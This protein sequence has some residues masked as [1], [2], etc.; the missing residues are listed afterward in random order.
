[1]TAPL[2]NNSSTLAKLLQA[3]Q[4]YVT[5]TPALL[6]E[7]LKRELTIKS[8]AEYNL[9]PELM[10]LLL[11][12]EAQ[13]A[14]TETSPSLKIVSAERGESSG[15]KSPKWTLETDTGE[16]LWVFQHKDPARNNFPLFDEAGWGAWLKGLPLNQATTPPHQMALKATKDTSGYYRVTE[17]LTFNPLILPTPPTIDPKHRVALEDAIQR[18]HVWTS[19]EMA[20]TKKYYVLDTETTGLETWDEVV[21]LSIADA[22]TGKLLLET[23]VKPYAAPIGFTAQDIHGITPEMVVNAP[24]IHEVKVNGVPLLDFLAAADGVI[25]WNADFDSRLVRQTFFV[26]GYA[27]LPAI[28]WECAMLLYG[29]YNGEW[30][31]KKG[32]YKWW[33]LVDA[34]RVEKI[35]TDYLPHTSHGDV[36]NTIALLNKIAS[37]YLPF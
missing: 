23:L 32:G 8:V 18:A 37:L 1:M 31:A 19:T 36:M 21:S 13:F 4:P 9:P 14:E 7:V 27:T 26:G 11:I 3:I 29:A 22:Q 16:R 24:P 34:I 6:T 33:K 5:T 28:Q 10:A 35:N 17:V 15:S 2:G 30:N 12:I 20:G 25:A